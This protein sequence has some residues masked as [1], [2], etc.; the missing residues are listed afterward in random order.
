LRI[1]L[2]EDN[3]GI[4]DMLQEALTL[5]GHHVSIYSKP[6]TFLAAVIPKHAPTTPA[7]FDLLII[8]LLLPETISGLQVI[9]S[10]KMLYPDLPVIVISAASHFYIVAALEALPGVKAFRKPFKVSDLLAA[11]QTQTSAG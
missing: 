11:I 3:A 1:G 8:D 2:L 7:S 4:C 6:T 5:A 10:V 9:H